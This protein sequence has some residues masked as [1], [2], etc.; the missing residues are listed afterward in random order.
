MEKL[1]TKKY[2]NTCN[3]EVYETVHTADTYRVDWYMINEK[4][5]CIGCYKRLKNYGK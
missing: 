1:P 4:I 2:C 3:R 5:I